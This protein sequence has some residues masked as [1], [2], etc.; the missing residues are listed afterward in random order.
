MMK[1]KRNIKRVLC[2]LLACA[3]MLSALSGCGGT[4]DADASVSPAVSDAAGGQSAQPSAEPSAGPA[5]MGSYEEIDQPEGWTLVVNKDGATLSYSKKS[6]MKLIEDNGY[7]FKDLDRDGELD[8]FEDWRV[9][10]KERSRDLVEN[11][12]LSLEFQMGMKMNPFSIGSADAKALA[13]TTKTALDLGYRHVR[14]NQG[15]AEVVVGWNNL[16]QEYIESN[17]DVVA[18]PATFIADPL[19]GNGV[20]DWPGNLALAATFDP[21]LAAQ[22]GETLSKEWRAMNLT[23]KVGP[24]VDLATE[25]RWSRNDMTFGEDPQL[26]MDMTTAMINAW[27]STYDEDGNDLGWGKDSVNVQ[28][29]HVMGE[30]AAEGGRE[31]HTLDGAYNVFPGGQFYTSIMPYFAAQNL[32][33]KTGSVSSA[34]TNFSIAVDENGDSIGGDR[35]ATSYNSWKI[36]DLWRG[37]NGWDGFILTDFNVHVDKCF[38]MEDATVPERL[39]KI[40]QAGVD[41]F[42]N[43]G[44]KYQEDIDT[45]MEAYNLGVSE[46]GQEGM[47]QIMSDSTRHILDTL[48][49]VGVVD[50]PYLSVDTCAS[51]PNNAEHAAAAREALLKSIVMLKN[52]DVIKAAGSEKKTVY[53]PYKYTPAK[54]SRGGT[55]PASVGPCMDV[56]LAMQYFNVV[57]D[58]PGTPSGPDGTYLPTDIIRAS[59]G[60]IAGCDL[61]LVRIASPKSANPTTGYDENMQVPAD[62]EYLPISLQYRPYTADNMYVRFESIGGQITVEEHEGVYG[63][64][65]D[66]VKENRSYFGKTGLI[67]NESDLDLVLEVAER[68]DN[69]VVIVDL[70]SSMI[71]SEFEPEVEGILVS[72][73]GGRTHS[74][75]D[76]ILFEI[77]AGNHEPSGLLPM[78]QPI[79]METVEAQYEDVPRD[80]ECYVDSDG[81][82]YDFA[83]GLNW[84]G[85]IDDER[86]AKY[87]VDPLVGEDPLG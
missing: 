23:M 64:E 87:N 24:Q 52:D 60:E 61:T 17:T 46:L 35:V 74:A 18:I 68:C 71:F 78:Q 67:S 32:P 10:Y 82:T 12:N 86:V 65:Y 57:T 66:Y 80:M 25:P 21:T 19:N 79:D 45:A 56:E 1:K 58:K 3:M 40:M 13:D 63:T 49:N 15:P 76:D 47:D 70:L 59:D 62:Y 11:G 55:T 41:A 42:G 34:M 44:G 33:G 7:A 38:G 30:C 36:N 2:L 8:V 20:T 9:D 48:F 29:K 6:G 51:V 4:P 27:Q 31:A 54:T 14:F 72:F 39:L 85:V 77:V 83:F 69:V 75:S 37:A 43:L 22:Y 81:N 26:S 50:H 84:S 16:I 53:I 5:A 28:V 73:G